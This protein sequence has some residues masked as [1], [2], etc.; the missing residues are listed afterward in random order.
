MYRNT[1]VVLT[2]M[3]TYREQVLRCNHD[4]RRATIIKKMK[5]GYNN[6]YLDRELRSWKFKMAFYSGEKP[7]GRWFLPSIFLNLCQD[8]VDRI[9]TGKFSASRHVILADWH[10]GLFFW[11][12]TQTWFDKRLRVNHQVLIDDK[13]WFELTL[14]KLRAFLKPNNSLGIQA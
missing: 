7:S 9:V 2:L 4:V 6:W 1:S 13:C 11:L 10:S 8:L 5:N 14:G 12:R 3:W